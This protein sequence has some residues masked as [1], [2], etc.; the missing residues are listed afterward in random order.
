MIV[1]VAVRGVHGGHVVLRGAQHGTLRA[2]VQAVGGVAHLTSEA[3]PT[4][5]GHI[6][7]RCVLVP[8]H[9]LASSCSASTTAAAATRTT[10]TG[11]DETCTLGRKRYT[12][13]RQK[14]LCG[15]PRI[16][17]LG[18]QVDGHITGLM[19]HAELKVFI[20]VHGHRTHAQ[21]V[22]ICA[23]HHSAIE[24]NDGFHA[25]GLQ[26]GTSFQLCRRQHVILGD[27]AGLREAQGVAGNQAV[28]LDQQFHCT[29]HYLNHAVVPGLLGFV[30]LVCLHCS[31]RIRT[32]M[33]VAAAV[34]LSWKLVHQ[35]HLLLNR[36]FGLEENALG[37]LEQSRCP[38][39]IRFQCVPK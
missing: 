39:Q 2:S 35:I 6:R 33:A 27:V 37:F 3:V 10:N 13:G 8:V 12:N 22:V 19:Q 14:G 1:I 24:L 30:L 15:V 29:A 4:T 9:V 5:R 26:H 18:V 38:L 34:G 11:T 20:E 17:L 16:D 36:R 25:H 7:V 32:V 28:V 31:G 23:R 21:R